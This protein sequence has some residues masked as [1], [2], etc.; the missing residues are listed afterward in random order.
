MNS[1]IQKMARIIVFQPAVAAAF[2][3]ALTGNT[4]GTTG[5][6]SGMVTDASG[7][8]AP[9]A[10][11][12]IL[13]ED[14]GVSRTVTSDA[15]GRYLAP[16]L[17]LGR[18]RVTAS[19]EGFQSEVRTGILLT[20]GREA[21]V[22][23][24][25]SV[26]A[27]AESVEVTGEAPLVNTTSSSVG[28]L[29]GA[30]QVEN[31]PLNG[32]SIDQ[33]AILQPAVS[34]TRYK[35]G[36]SYRGQNDK[37]TVQGARP[38]QNIFLLDGTDIN[39]SRNRTPGSV[40]GRLMGVE[41]LRE[42]R[43]ETS[44]YSAEFGS[45]GGGV[46]VMA[47]KSGTNAFHGSVYEYLRNDNFDARNFF[48]GERKPEFKRNN[49]GFS[50]GGPLRKDRTF[51]FGNLEALRERLG[52]TTPAIVPNGLTRQGFLPNASGGLDNVGVDPQV[53]PYLDFYPAPNGRGYIDGTADSIN[54][55]SNPTNEMF[56]SMRVDHNFSDRHSVFSRYTLSDGDRLTFGI[57]PWLPTSFD[58]KN[59][60]LTIEEKAVISPETLNIARFG[61]TRSFALQER[62][63]LKDI[64]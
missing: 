38:S 60:Y 35:T 3:L 5:T 54:T 56:F 26:G 22:R 25:L 64:S 34:F 61:F 15:A 32:R 62:S 55:T 27:V 21:V 36:S 37:L 23:F 8:V 1:N 53:R 2:L 40:G 4:Q 47:S 50:L 9:G 16:S 39:D 51:F 44:S 43:I 28:E 12:V 46:I 41:G 58:S 49:F 24:Q 13:N 42:F 11:L 45:A 7:A 18:Y 59:Q 29:V 63:R 52:V 10:T 6:I 33:L 30:A 14:T 48:D 17:N 31:L 19:L 57:I 20:V